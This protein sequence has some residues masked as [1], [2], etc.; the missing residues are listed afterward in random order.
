MYQ[1]GQKTSLIT[2][3]SAEFY[4]TLED[5][6]KIG[7]KTSD[8]RCLVIIKE[9]GKQHYLQ[10]FNTDKGFIWLRGDK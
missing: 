8:T 9:F 4:K 1:V 2:T 7:E 10:R 6:K 3:F 5:A